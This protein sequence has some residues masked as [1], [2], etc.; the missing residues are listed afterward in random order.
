MRRTTI[1]ACLAAAA[2]LTTIALA[3]PASA[4][5]VSNPPAPGEIEA[6]V[7]RVRDLLP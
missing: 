1:S 6:C 7:D 4:C 3:T 5:A 2:V